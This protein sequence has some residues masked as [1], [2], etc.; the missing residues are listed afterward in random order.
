MQS[1]DPKDIEKYFD[2]LW[3]IC[4]SITGDGLRKSYKILSELIPLKLTEVKTGTNV[5]DWVIPKEWNVRSAY[6]ITPDGKKIA[7]LSKNNLHVVGYSTP[8]DKEMS[9]EEL[10]KHLYTLPRLPNAIPYI[11]SYYSE[12]WGFCVSQNEFDALPKQGKYKVVIDS[13]LK[14]G[15]LTYGD[16]ILKGETSDEIL[17]SSYLCHPSMANNE[18]SGPLVLSFLYQLVAAMPKRRY[19]YRFV[20]CPET[21]GTIAYLHQ[22]KQTILDHV[23]GGFVLTCCGTS[24][25]FVYKK[26]RR[27][28]SQTDKIAEH[29]L[30]HSGSHYSIIGFD[31][32][33]SD[34]RQYCSPGF[35]L[36]VGSLMRSKYHEYNEYHTSLDNK[37]LIS[38]EALK[39]TVE[40]Y[41]K[42]IEVFELD[43]IYINTIQFCEPNMGKRNLYEDLSGA[44]VMPDQIAR[45]MRL[46]NYMDGQHSLLDFCEKYGLHILDLK[47]EIQLLLNKGVL[48]R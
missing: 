25:P 9:Y 37:E 48:K 4:R 44:L 2:D 24:K 34:E 39:E 26:S 27:E 7:D 13:E 18:L 21:I 1:I 16:C 20:L 41:F 10:I 12:K 8:V 38:F 11:T 14:D 5:F 46:I 29:I 43:Q 15:S 28:T 22:N 19:T 35:N 6:I 17:I 47:D 31:P 45:R 23:R 36:A 32:I 3:P 30:K 42:M 40:M 33:G